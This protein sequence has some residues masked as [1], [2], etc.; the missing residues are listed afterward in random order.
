MSSGKK[1]QNYQ[2]AKGENE[3]GDLQEKNKLCIDKKTD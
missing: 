3:D 2:K 1:L